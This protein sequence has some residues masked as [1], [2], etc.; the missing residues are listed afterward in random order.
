MATAVDDFGAPLPTGSGLAERIVS[1][2]PTATEALFAMG[3]GARLVGRSRWDT[4]PAEAQ[5]VP[6]VGDGIR[7]NVEAVLAVRPSLVLLYASPENRAAAESFRRAGVPTVALRVDRIAQFQTLLHTL[8]RLVGDSLRAAQ[9]GDSVQRT[10]DR[11]RTITA[12]S[13]ARPTV[14][15]PVWDSPPMVIGGGSYLDELIE[16]AGGRNVFHDDA[17]PSPTVSL[18]EILRRAPERVVASMRSV[19][20][21]PTRSGWRDLPA[22]RARHFVVE[23]PNVTGRPSVVLGMAAVQLARALH[24]ELADSLP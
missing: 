13:A 15:W 11:V 14:L 18:E 2:N 22:I 1:L 24:P 5:Q 4:F 17:A 21:L 20:Q 3:A 12:R 9:V 6:D 23:D 19:E 10:L 8:G 16:I 7:P